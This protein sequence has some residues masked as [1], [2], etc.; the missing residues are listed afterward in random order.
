MRPKLGPRVE[1][2]KFRAEM[3]AA[4]AFYAELN[5]KKTECF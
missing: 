5:S 3:K 1:K 2:F 4:A